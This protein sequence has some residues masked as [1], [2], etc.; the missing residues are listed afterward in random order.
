MSDSK[1]EIKDILRQYKEYLNTEEA[2][3]HLQTMEKEKKEVHDLMDKLSQM[4]KKGDEFTELVLYG[5]LPY[6]NTKVAKRVSLFPAFMNI[7]IFFKAYNY[8]NDEW[9]LIAN[10]IYTL[11]IKF[12]ENP[13]KMSEYIVEFTKDKYHRRLQCGSITPILFCINDNYP[14]VNNRAIRTFRSIKIILGEKG[15]LSQKLIDYTDNI[16]K[17]DKLIAHLGLEILKNHN[18]QDLFFYWYD[19]EILSEERRA[20]KKESEEGETETETEE[21]VKKE[22]IDIIQF[23]EDV[24]LEKGFDFTP[25][26]LGDPQRIKINQIISSSSKA[27]WVL[28]HFQR[29]FDWNKNDVRD[30]WESI[31]NDYYVGSFLLWDTDR[32]P[33]LGIQPIL[34]VIKSEED[35]R[36]D[37]II[38]D[39]QQRITSLHYA[40]KAPKF[41]LRG[42]KIPVYLYV[43]FNHYL[44]SNSKYGVIEIHTKRISE[45]D[46]FRLMLFPLYEL[47]KYSQWVDKF[48][49]FL[50]SQTEDQNK[51]RKIRRIVDKK[52][53]HMWEG[54]EIP[55]I[56]LPESMELFQV[57][58]I[59]E[60][61]NTKGKLLS[62]FDL[63][64][65]RL[66]KNNIELKKIWDATLKDYPNIARYSKTISKT[67]IYILQA[68]SLLYE[69]TSSAKR[70]DILDI[71]S[72]VYENSDR[73]F[74][75][76]WDEVAE[77][78]NKAI[79]KL[80][81]MRDGFGVKDDK[82]LPFAPMIPVLTALLKVID[83]KDAKAKCYKKLS[84]W[85]WSAIFTNAY[86]S[87]A[88]SQMTQDFKEIKKWFDNDEEIPKT[89]TQMTREVPNL[90][91]RDIQSKS[92]AK[93]RG[94]MSLIAIEGAKDFDTS[95]TL[96]NARG[97]DKDHIFP[98]SFNF[99]FGSNKHVHSILNMTWMSDSTN[100]RIKRCKKPTLY[101]TE[102]IK[103]KYNNNKDQYLDILKTHFIN[104]K[105]Y[106]YL[107]EDNFEEFI[108]EREKTIISKIKKI[109]DYDEVK[110]EKTLISPANPFT[111]RIIFLNMLK[112]CDE[113]VY[114]LDK[115]FS[116]YG[117]ELLAESITNNVKEIKVIMSIDK[118]DDSFRSLFKNFKK[119]MANRSINSKLKV[120]IDSKTKSSI[121]D[122]FI[123]TE[124]DSYNIPSPDIIARG[125]L[126]EISKSSNKDKL[127]KEFDDLWNKSKD[128]IQDWNDIKDKLKQ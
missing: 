110:K 29:Y 90:Y 84:K 125:Q 20:S 8:S 87:A 103:T 11:C 65:A 78:T 21:E 116:H 57:T 73:D 52:L 18:Y 46:S 38:L 85:Y 86:S 5:L 30:F 50:L 62:V 48:E 36:P 64:I 39:G 67:P 91:F 102:F 105:A 93:Y 126:S 88:D 114:W 101:V 12:K 106:D 127:K 109:I 113:Y 13:K 112:S 4:D 107:I 49:D 61:I 118:V 97:N 72:N 9:N 37:S 122:R 96:E 40:I 59:F 16:K 80:E 42:S 44:N 98:K 92:N 6:S 45:E 35:I 89:I 2:K 41:A 43:N 94:V 1:K 56:A 121:H 60:N 76:D 108:S 58:D 63:L 17:I 51:V 27:R 100:R 79:E 95:Q 34:G 71:Y 53:R 75:E 119:E 26:S 69:K 104:Q 66:Y 120:I 25:H 117:L 3:E 77:F 28:P 124:Y 7:M 70:A 14:I 10:R 47:E 99:G 32:N 24:N 22:E 83:E 15:K 19:S 55:Y 31:F 128:I 33:E 115:Y 54:F 81:N 82:E 74:E 23:I 123:I 111:N 68:M